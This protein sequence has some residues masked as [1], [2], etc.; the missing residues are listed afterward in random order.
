MRQL[1]ALI[2]AL[3]MGIAGWAPQPA[4]EPPAAV[5]PAP[6]V[7][8]WEADPKGYVLEQL[9]ALLEEG[10]WNV[11][12]WIFPGSGPMSES[13]PE[14]EFGKALRGVFA[15]YDWQLT[16]APEYDENAV[17][18]PDSYSISIYP[19]Y[20]TPAEAAR[21]IFCET[22]S[23]VLHLSAWSGEEEY[24]D[25]FFTAPGAENLCQDIADL[26]PYWSAVTGCRT[27]T[28]PQDTPL[29]TARAYLEGTFAILR[30]KGHILDERIDSLEYL[31]PEWDGESV[32]TGYMTYDDSVAVHF[33]A[34]FSLK[35]TKP[36]LTGWQN[37]GVDEEG[38]AHEA[39]A[40]IV[41]TLG[42]DGLYELSWYETPAEE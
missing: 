1:L 40:K 22:G 30:E 26:C 6:A 5:T 31:P 11:R 29:A 18:P 21:P 13:F 36:Q 35:P 4:P 27:R 37:I 9:D 3:G 38:W 23:P 28:A 25:L 19:N 7:R 39:Y 10:Q 32:G 33:R 15:A 34:E 16:Q 41:I 17:Y 14:A 24:G 42:G 2:L 12:F 20:M 8:P